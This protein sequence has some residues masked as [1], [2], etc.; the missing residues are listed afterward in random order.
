MSRTVVG[1]LRG[2]PSSEYDV[3]LKTGA[4]ILNALSDDHYR[5][6]D[7]LIDKQGRWHRTGR[8][9]DPY[10]AVH[11]MD[12]VVNGLHGEYGEDGTVQRM[13]ERFSVP[14]TG[15]RPEA[16]ALS[17]HKQRTKDVLRSAGVRV[18]RGFH[19]TLPTIATSADMAREVFQQ[20]A[21]PY[22]IKPAFG[23][24]TVGLSLAPTLHDLNE[25]LADALDDHQSVLVEEY[26]PGHEATV[27]V[28]DDFRDHEVYA[29]PPI[30][31]VLGPKQIFDYEAKYVAATQELC[32][33]TFHHD[34]KRELEEA[35]KIAHK[36]LG[37]THYSRSD[38]RIHP[39]GT[40]YFLETNAL[41]GLTET[42][43]IPKA[44]TAVGSSLK[45]F[46]RHI[47]GKAMGR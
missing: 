2:G 13:L 34:I 25:Q 16:A 24:S 9:M 43:L 6:V 20:F 17:M 41:P 21:P 8:T 3:S 32:P 46:L 26:I 44:L 39:S 40:I 11:D 42:S 45:E 30:E 36:M 7:I 37:L 1:V 19:Y 14:Y 12:V 22:I 28:I 4:S 29:L 31:I 47:I 15:P 33:S 35:A 38:F 10:R 27:G 18:P 23:G 5:P